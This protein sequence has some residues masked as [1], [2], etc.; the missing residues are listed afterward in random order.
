MLPK[1]HSQQRQNLNNAN[2]VASKGST[3]WI[4]HV[5]CSMFG[6]NVCDEPKDTNN[7]IRGWGHITC[8]G[9]IASIEAL[10][11]A[12]NLKCFTFAL[13]AVLRNEPELRAAHDM[14]VP[15]AAINRYSLQTLGMAGFTRRFLADVQAAPVFSCPEQNSTPSPKQPPC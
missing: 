7:M 3:T 2:N 9:T 1:A 6:Y 8:G 10:R 5:L 14:S 12:R 11:S 13:Q 15:A 4:G